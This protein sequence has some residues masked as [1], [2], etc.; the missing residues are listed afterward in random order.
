MLKFN[1]NTIRPKNSPPTTGSRIN[2]NGFTMVE[3]AIVIIVLGVL[4]AGAIIFYDQW[5]KNERIRITNERIDVIQDAIQSFVQVN[6]FLPCPARLDAALDAPPVGMPGTPGYIP[7]YGEA[8]NCNEPVLPP[9]IFE[10]IGRAGE[11][12]RIGAIPT[13]ALSIPDEY[14]A[15]SWG[16]RF[17]FAIT[18]A[19]AESD[20]GYR[21]TRGAIFMRDATGN[22]VLNTGGN[23]L[24]QPDGLAMY[25]IASHGENGV[26]AY[27][28]GSGAL[29]LPCGSAQESENCDNDAFFKK[30]LLRADVQTNQQFDDRVIYEIKDFVEIQ[31]I[32]RYFADVFPCNVTGPG[33]NIFGDNCASAMSDGAGVHVDIASGETVQADGILLYSNTLTSETDGRLIVRATLTVSTDNDGIPE[34]QRW[35]EAIHVAIFVDGAQVTEGVI[36]NPAYTNDDDSEG[37][38]GLVMGSI[39]GLTQGTDYTVEVYLFSFGNANATPGAMTLSAGS[40]RHTEHSGNAVIEIMEIRDL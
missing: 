2:A 22:S 16:N 27:D 13:R 25:V 30:T 36:L 39:P 15:D 26:G 7:G 14:A 10:D 6:S 8:S 1:P 34:P 20:V 5:T 29:K 38:S 3:M 33:N 11:I 18:R 19:M 12:I 28:I 37:F 24:N 32:N 4:I 9:G 40:I 21:T 31:A 35:E 23:S 17:T